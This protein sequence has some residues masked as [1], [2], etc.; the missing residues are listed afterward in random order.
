M[1][2]IPQKIKKL[3]VLM[4]LSQAE[5]ARRVGMLPSHLNVYLQGKGD[6]HSGRF[7]EILAECGIDIEELVDKK[8]AVR[9]KGDS[10]SAA[11][12]LSVSEAVA[13]LRRMPRAEVQAISLIL[14]KIGTDRRKSKGRKREWHA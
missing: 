13:K 4:G 10:A 6:I 5:L 9:I 2:G 1:G 11:I 14:G 7:I 3:S 8:L 12:D